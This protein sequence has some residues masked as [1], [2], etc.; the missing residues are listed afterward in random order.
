MSAAIYILLL[1]GITRRQYVSGK[2]IF[3][4]MNDFFSMQQRYPVTL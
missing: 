1:N 2:I 3:V 4:K